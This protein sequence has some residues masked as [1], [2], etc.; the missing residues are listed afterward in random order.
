MF[1]KIKNV[2]TQLAPKP[3]TPF[4]KIGGEQG[5]KRLVDEFYRV[6][7]TAPEA[8]R[9]RDLHRESLAEANHKLYMFLSGWLGGPNLYIEKYGHPRM[10]KRHFPFVIT[11]IE[12]D[13]WL[14]CMKKSLERHPARDKFKTELY[15][16]F[17]AFA[18]HMRNH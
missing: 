11:T 12:R 5:L 16:S 18:E 3:K 4:E 8:K 14:W 1:E 17:K 9:C 10:R 15:E 2:L 13:E 6:M 7:D